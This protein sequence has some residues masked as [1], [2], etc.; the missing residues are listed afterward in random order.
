MVQILILRFT[1]NRPPISVFGWSQN[2]KLKFA[3]GIAVY[4]C[5]NFILVSCE[6]KQ[7]IDDCELGFVAFDQMFYMLLLFSLW[8][9]DMSTCV[10]VSCMLV[11]VSVA[12]TVLN[13]NVHDV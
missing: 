10:V 1:V 6:I 11:L 8:G 3:G 7:D 5:T 9:N 12:A 13:F 2:F 4:T